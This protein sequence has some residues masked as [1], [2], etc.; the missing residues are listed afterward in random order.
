[1]KK[2]ALLVAVALALFNW[3]GKSQ[4]KV[5]GLGSDELLESVADLIEVDGID[6][7]VSNLNIL[8]APA[9]RPQLSRISTVPLGGDLRQTL[10]PDTSN[11]LH[12]FNIGLR[13]DAFLLA[14]HSGRRRIIDEIDEDWRSSW[15]GASPENRIFISFAREDSQYAESIRNALDLLG[16]ET[17]LYLSQDGSMR[18]NSVEV[19]TYFREAGQ[20]LIIDTPR[21]RQSPAVMAEVAA[22]GALRRPSVPLFT[23]PYSPPARVPGTGAPPPAS[24]AEIDRLLREFGVRRDRNRGATSP[25]MQEQCCWLVYYRNGREIRREN[26]CGNDCLNAR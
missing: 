7:R 17:F 20:H 6:V 24:N 5:I 16:Y 14:I 18:M 13:R 21:A 23:P 8:T 12:L 26:V 11:F 19:G 15:N 2:L 22:F 4:S 25:W 9:A 1:M 10:T 3:T